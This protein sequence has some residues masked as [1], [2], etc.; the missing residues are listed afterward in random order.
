LFVSLILI[1]LFVSLIEN[2]PVV[3][4]KKQPSNIKL[5]QEATVTFGESNC[6]VMSEKAGARILTLI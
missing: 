4:Q 3:E 1:L 5:L 6:E 2:I